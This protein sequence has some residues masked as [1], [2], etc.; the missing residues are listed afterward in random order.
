MALAPVALGAPPDAAA[1]AARALEG[2][3]RLIPGWL[4]IAVTDELSLLL[5]ARIDAVPTS[6]DPCRAEARSAIAGRIGIS[7][8]L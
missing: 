8:A 1:L 3:V 7:L 4:A 5:D 2:T 6:P